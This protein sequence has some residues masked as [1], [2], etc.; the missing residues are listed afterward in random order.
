LCEKRLAADWRERFGHPLVLIET[1]VDPQ[2]FRGTVYLAANWVYLGETRGYR[3][4]RHGY[5]RTAVSAKKVF[6][7]PLQSDARAVLARPVLEPSYRTGGSKIMLTAAQ[8][9]SLPEFF[10]EIPDPRR[11]QGRRHR[12]SVVLAIAAAA[13]LCGMRGY[14]AISDWAKSLGAKGR[15]R[16]GCRR[17]DGRYVVPSEYIM[18]DVLIRIDPA[19]LDRALQRW[20]AL[21]GQPDETLAIDGK[22]LRNAVDDEGHQTHV[23]SLIGHETKACYAQEKVGALPVEG[24]TEE[25]KQTNE[26][27]I[28]IPLLD[29]VEVEGKDITADAMLTQRKLAEYLVETRK[30]H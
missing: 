13:T 8:M 4:V 30:A 11:A 7:R 28:A 25:L 23:M 2:R 20:N 24:N 17:Q 3:R 1:F 26:I 12:L 14:K 21:Y 29:N 15:E 9:R 18:R 5:S 10:A 6:V 27:K 22:T 19:A 16:F